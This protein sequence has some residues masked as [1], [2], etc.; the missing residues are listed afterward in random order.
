M[1]EEKS[2]NFT[3]GMTWNPSKALRSQPILPDRHQADRI[4][5]RRFDADNYPSLG[6]TLAAL[7]AG[8]RSSSSTGQHP[9]AR[10]DLPS[11]QRRAPGRGKLNT[12]RLS[13]TA[14]P[15]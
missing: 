13:I 8:Q 1:K 15:R 6:A 12:F 7:G 10:F 2:N 9:H 14:G 5:L 11:P 4:A 3:L